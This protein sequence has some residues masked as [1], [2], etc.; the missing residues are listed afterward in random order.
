MA[1]V[2]RSAVT[3]EAALEGLEAALIHGLLLEAHEGKWGR[4][5]LEQEARKSMMEQMPEVQSLL[6]QWP[7]TYGQMKEWPK[8]LLPEEIPPKRS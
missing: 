7:Q 8:E 3:T 4:Y 1:K 6:A 5:K 2:S